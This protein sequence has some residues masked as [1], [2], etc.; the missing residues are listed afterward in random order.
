MP[1]APFTDAE[2]PDNPYPGTRPGVS[3]VH[4]DGVGRPLRSD[5]ATPW[6]WLVH[7]NDTE[8]ELG[9][10]LA[11]RGAPSLAERIPVLAYGSNANPS[12]V[13]WLRWTLGLTGPV[14][15]LRVHCTGLAAVW[16]A[17]LRV[18]DGQR[19]ATLMAE[20]GREEW[21]AVWLATPEQVRVLD[22]C[23]GRG[24]RYR[25]VRLGSGALT[26]EDGTILDGVLAY[27]AAS[28]LRAPLLVADRPV[29]CA[30]VAQ[31]PAAALVGRPGPDGL[32]VTPVAGDPAADDWPDRLFVHGTDGTAWDRVRPHMVGE[33]EPSGLPADRHDTGEV[34]GW[35]LTLREPADALADLDRH[36]GA[37]HRRERVVDAHGRLCWTYL[38]G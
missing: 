4:D 34:S 10:W 30:D 1:P 14:V 3:F 18:R 15:V 9:D 26:T 6:R 35:T 13:T 32:A 36:E 31:V 33:P 7:E 22:R 37:D 11:E 20:P 29:R 25:L 16:A 17:V 21:H 19:P 38:S 28:D 12:K 8:V 5:P 2:Y 24:V 23:E 27:T